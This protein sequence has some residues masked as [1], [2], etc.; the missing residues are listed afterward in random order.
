MYAIGLDIGGTKI[1]AS[2]VD[3]KG[4]C[5]FKKV[6][7]SVAYDSEAMFLQVVDCIKDVIRESGYGND[8]I[9][10][11]GVGVPGKI[12]AEKGIAI[13]QN[14]LPWRSFPLIER[15][16][17]VFPYKMIMGNDVAM[18]AHGEW[19]IAG[20]NMKDTFVYFTW[21]TGVSSS[22]I[23]EGRLFKGKGFAGELGLIFQESDNQR[24]EAQVSGPSISSICSQKLRQTLTTK[25]IISEYE[26]GDATVVNLMEPIMRKI[27]KGVYAIIC[28]L[29]PHKIVFGGSV[30]INNPFLLEILKKELLC[31]VIPEQNLSLEKM[32]VSTLGDN[33]IVG[34]GLKVLDENRSNAN[35]SENY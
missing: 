1:A 13:Y 4:A 9:V 16:Q 15:L 14:N 31:M 10:G 19:V 24:L 7:P 2:L 33:G 32:F 26:R 22:V 35:Y 29:D 11:I 20:K 17:A 23:H 27:A 12:D 34:A 28:L 18:A 5:S 3:E 8:R 21:S 6:Y 25:E 30:I